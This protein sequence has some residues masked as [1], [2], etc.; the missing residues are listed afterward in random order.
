MSLRA[1]AAQTIRQV[2]NDGKSLAE[3]MP[4]AQQKFDDSRDKALLK[5]IVYGVLRHYRRLSALRDQ[6][7]SQKLKEPNGAL[8]CLLLVGLYQ[9]FYTR[10]PGHAAVAATVDGVDEINE[11]RARGLVNAILRRAQREGENRLSKIDRNWELLHSHPDWFIEALKTQDKSSVLA[12]LEANNH[13]APMTLRV[14]RRKLNRD[15]YLS[16]LNALGINATAHPEAPDALTLQDPLDVNQLPG[17]ADGEV[18]VQDAAAQL[19]ADYL[20]LQPGLSVLDA[21]AAPGGKTAHMLER[22]HTLKVLALDNDSTRLQRVQENLSRLQ[23]QAELRCADASDTKSWWNGKAFD[24]ILLDAPCSGTGVIRRHPDIKWLRR[25][26]D[27]PAL[28][29]T[30]LQMLN[31]L[32]PTLA[33]GGLLL[34][35]TCSAL[36]AENA[37][38]I[39][40][41]LTERAADKQGSAKLLPLPGQ[42]AGETGRVIRCGEQ[43]MDGFYYA[44]LQKI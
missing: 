1:L 4:L 34:Y 12:I 19:C 37:E 32:W 10:V 28:A 42:H 24:R 38:V 41:F 36:R 3:L 22:E 13:P 33:D 18:S 9:L 6:L 16:K 44:L 39:E 17:F 43:Q 26:R 35:A 23:L 20:Q 30:Q 29:A 11:P 15:A 2:V 31:R 7:L 14:N 25:E 8:G 21:C 27:I 5:E 40:R